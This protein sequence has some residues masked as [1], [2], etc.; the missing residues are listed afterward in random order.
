MTDSDRRRQGALQLFVG[1]LGFMLVTLPLAL[2]S[3]LHRASADAN[4]YGGPLR[5]GAFEYA[6]P[7]YVVVAIGAIWLCFG[8][9][10]W[11]EATDDDKRA[12]TPEPHEDS[13]D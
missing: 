6:W 3:D 8:F 9:F 2:L 4:S 7:V 11:S 12:G 5:V 10:E 1:A 13:I